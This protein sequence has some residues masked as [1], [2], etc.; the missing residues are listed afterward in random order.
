[1]LQQIEQRIPNQVSAIYSM[2]Q[3][4]G[5]MSKKRFSSALQHEH[6][7]IIFQTNFI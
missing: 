7:D 1:M 5:A 3:N 6:E 2:L 4:V